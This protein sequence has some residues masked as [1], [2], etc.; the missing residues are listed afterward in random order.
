MGSISWSLLVQ[1]YTFSKSTASIHSN[2][3]CF[4]YFLP[5]VVLLFSVSFVSRILH[6]RFPL[7]CMWLYLCS[8]KF[9]RDL[10]ESLSRWCLCARATW[11]SQF[12]MCALT[13]WRSALDQNTRW[14]AIL[15]HRLVCTAAKISCGPERLS[16][17]WDTLLFINQNTLRR[18]MQWC[19]TEKCSCL[20]ILPFVC[21]TFM[22]QPGRAV[23]FSLWRVKYTF[24]H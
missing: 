5:L 24:W 15:E 2:I 4:Y 17:S 23:S 12:T 18:W 20:S 16:G 21:A 22:C 19:F 1:I 7:P 3:K 13:Q 14:A 10:W 11:Q 6:I 8:L 9:L